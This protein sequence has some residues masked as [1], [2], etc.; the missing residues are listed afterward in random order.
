MKLEKLIGQLIIRDPQRAEATLQADIRQLLLTAGLNLKDENLSDVNLEAHVGGGRRIDIEIGATAIEVKRNLRLG[1]ARKDGEEQLGEYIQLRQAQFGSRYAGILTDGAEWICYRLQQGQLVKVSELTVT[2]SK[3]DIARLPVWLE[4]VLATARDVKPTP[5]TIYTRLGAGSSSHALDRSTLAALYEEHK[6]KPVVKTKRLLWARLLRTA[7]G[8]QFEGTDDLFVEHTLLV[9]SAEII[10]HAVVGLDVEHIV[11]A[12]LLSGAKFDESE[13][14]GVVEADFFDWVVGLPTGDVFVRALA[15]RLARFDWGSVDHD[16]LKVLYESVIPP[17]TRKKLGEYYTP[18]W[19]AQVIVDTV[20]TQPLEQRVLDPA[21]GSG[22]FL[23]HSVRRY[24]AEAESKGMPVKAM[25]DGVTSRVFGMDLHPVAVTLA[26]VTYLL[27]IGRERLTGGDRGPIQIPVYLGDSIQWRQQS[28]S[29]LSDK[30]LKIS[31]DDDHT[32]FPEELK[33]P[34]VLLRDSRVFD[35]LVKKLAAKSSDPKRA[36]KS[37]PPSLSGVFQLLAIPKEAHK[38]VE[39]TF[40]IMCDLHDQG[41]DHIWG[42]YVRNLARPEWLAMAANQVDVLIGNPP[43]LSYRFMPEKMQGEFRQLC[44][45]RSLWSGK[46]VATQ[47][48]LSALFAVRT[49]ELY[50]KLNGKFGFV[51]PDAALDRNQFK[52]FRAGH[53]DSAGRIKRATFTTSWDLR[54]LRPHFFPRGASVVF[55]SRTDSAGPMLKEAEGWRGNL[56][57]GKSSWR[58]VA[59]AVQRSTPQPA[60]EVQYAPSPYRARFRNGASLFPRLFFLVDKKAPGPLGLVSGKVGVRSATSPYENEPWKSLPRQEGVVETEFLRPVH[61][62]A[63]VLPYRMLEPEYAV[64]PRDPEGLMDSKIERMEQYPGLS[65]WWGKCEEIWNASPSS[66]GFPLAQ[67]LDFHAELSS[68]F[69]IQ[70][71]RIVYTKSGMHLSAARLSDH[72]AVIDHTLYWASASSVEEA[73][74]LCAILNSVIITARV[75]PLMAYGKD[76]RHI[77]KAVWRLPI[78]Q[79]DPERELHAELADL[80]RQAEE[81]VAALSL[82]LTK[83]FPWLRKVVRSHLKESEVGQRI[84]ASVCALLD[85]AQPITSPP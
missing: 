22:T 18:D 47:Q 30:E 67:R 80:G 70:P 21:C 16:V 55:G 73:Y 77:D 32:L 65:E 31:T 33:F 51:M 3:Q 50:L 11:P 48:D 29:L 78:P 10:A 27:A 54:R 43:W 1:N 17:E 74:Y 13:I 59:Q 69:P 68:Q 84:E 14:Y 40:Q 2:A 60:P 85:E 66:E 79:F 45:D 58:D 7:L 62:G 75:R 36:P 38:T 5:H 37:K 26:R 49:I 56:P 35:E 83:H 19:L 82:D 15:R 81:M 64:V 12:S 63:T 4:G 24:I 42:Y 46:S 39:A 71:H 76:E 61:L 8:T 57:R 53:Y 72:R 25:L 28:P 41:R 52:G 23:F 6:E 9:N 44:R 34:S 20:V